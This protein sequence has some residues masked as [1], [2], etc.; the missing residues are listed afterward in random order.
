ML[1]YDWFIRWL[2]AKFFHI[3]KCLGLSTKEF[4]LFGKEGAITIPDCKLWS[5]DEV[6][7]KRQLEIDTE[8]LNYCPMSISA[9]IILSS[10]KMYQQNE[11]PNDMDRLISL[12][13][14]RDQGWYGKGVCRFYTY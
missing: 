7:E 6:L 14:C 9:P 2:F 4:S 5:F 3:V 8:M 1:L 12:V 10:A 11:I 13:V